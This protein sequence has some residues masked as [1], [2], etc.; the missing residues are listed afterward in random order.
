MS[1]KVKIR[2]APEKFACSVLASIEN[3]EISIYFW[4]EMRAQYLFLI[5][6]CWQGFVLLLFTQRMGVISIVLNKDF[7]ETLQKVPPKDKKY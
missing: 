6:E 4:I 3:T 7:N 5:E 1:Q 2:P